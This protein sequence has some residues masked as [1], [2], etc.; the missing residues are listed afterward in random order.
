M[1]SICAW[2][3][4]PAIRLMGIQFEASDT[5]EKMRTVFDRWSRLLIPAPGV[6]KESTFLGNVPAIHIAPSRHATDRVLFFLHGGGYVFESANGS[7]HFPAKLVKSARVHGY[8]PDY[9]LAPEHPYPAALND[10]LCEEPLWLEIYPPEKI[11]LAGDSAGGGLVVAMMHRLRDSHLP[12]PSCG[13]LFCPW[14]D[15][16]GS[17]DSMRTNEVTELFMKPRTLA[18]MARWYAAGND[19]AHS[20]ISPLFGRQD[21]LPPLLAQVST[22]EGLRSDTERFVESARSVGVDVKLEIYQDMWHVWQLFAPLVR[23]SREAILNA[24]DFLA[25]HMD[26]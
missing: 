6:H 4:R 5:P 16:T 1:S 10:V 19:L 24:T 2:L 23:E 17:G 20:E 22:S 13:V 15:L 25:A 21:G 8:I 18:R 3:H 11:A 14:L 12:Q 9:R 26:R 7:R